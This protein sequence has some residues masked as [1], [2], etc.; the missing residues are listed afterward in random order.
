M[1][2]SYFRGFGKFVD[3]AKGLRMGYE[4]NMFYEKSLFMLACKINVTLFLSNRGN[5][6]FTKIARCQQ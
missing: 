4:H 6:M 3:Q 1:D 2:E 5:K